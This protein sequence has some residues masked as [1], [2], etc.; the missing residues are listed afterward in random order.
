VPGYNGR[1][2]HH[3][4]YDPSRAVDERRRRG[5]IYSRRRFVPITIIS[6]LTVPQ[7]EQTSRSRQ[8]DGAA[9]SLHLLGG[10]GLDL[11]AAF[12]APHYETNARKSGSAKGHRR[13]RLGF[14]RRLRHN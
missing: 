7:R 3:G 8:W 2:R 5:S 12:P 13:V 10:I 9:V 6:G 11:M 4:R 14:H 1:A